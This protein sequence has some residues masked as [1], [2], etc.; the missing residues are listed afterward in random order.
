MLFYIEFKKKL[1][2]QLRVREHD[3]PYMIYC[4]V[5]FPT[6]HLDI[7]TNNGRPYFPCFTWY[8]Q[9]SSSGKFLDQGLNCIRSLWSSFCARTTNIHFHTNGEH[10]D[11]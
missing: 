2:V 6:M 8:R 10:F 7:K 11:L 5:L 1:G 3:L 4:K 9:F